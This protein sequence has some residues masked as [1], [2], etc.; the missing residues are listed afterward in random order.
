MLKLLWDIVQ[1]YDS[2][3]GISSQRLNN[4]LTGYV[5]PH[6]DEIAAIAD[7]YSFPQLIPYYCATSC[8]FGPQLGDFEFQDIDHIVNKLHE[9]LQHPNPLLDRICALLQDAQITIDEYSEWIHI[10]LELK[11]LSQCFFGLK[12]WAISNGYLS[13][14][15]GKPAPKTEIFQQ[16]RVSLGLSQ[17]EAGKRIGVSRVTISNIERQK[18]SSDSRNRDLFENINRLAIAY[19]APELRDYY[20]KH[21]CPLLGDEPPL[22]FKPD[23]LGEIA[24]QLIS[25]LILCKNTGKTL[26]DIVSDGTISDH[27]LAQFM[28][29]F[30]ILDQMIYAVNSIL[31]W[32][33]STFFNQLRNPICGDICTDKAARM[34]EIIHK[35]T[36]LGEDPVAITQLYNS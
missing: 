2:N 8:S 25:T 16:T 15:P 5:K 11:T 29:A 7:A 6:P 36:I 4:I 33:R 27:E 30:Y 32:T 9:K 35:L 22:K 23:E 18:Y 19:Q 13:L 34:K 14:D 24:T 1:R 20:C 21:N 17:A 3:T 28:N 26:S 12:I 31:L 10:L